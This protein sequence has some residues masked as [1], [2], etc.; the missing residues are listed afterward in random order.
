MDAITLQVKVKPNA[1]TSSL[2]QVDDGSWVATLKSPPVDGKAN[3]E[4]IAL[5]AGHFGCHKADVS[6]KAGAGG[7]IKL[8]KRLSLNAEYFYQFNRPEASM[9]ENSFAIGFDIETGLWEWTEDGTEGTQ[10]QQTVGQRRSQVD[11]QRR[12]AVQEATG[13]E[14]TQPERGA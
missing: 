13:R 9:M 7:R 10:A 2:A 6:I 3:T 1:R 12:I 4:L 11:D 14:S 8:T 5:V